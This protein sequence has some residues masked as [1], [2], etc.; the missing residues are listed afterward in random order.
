[1]M[2]LAALLAFN[3]T[4]SVILV[5]N[6]ITWILYVDL[7][8]RMARRRLG[9]LVGGGHVRGGSSRRMPASI[10]GQLWTLRDRPSAR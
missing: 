9:A 10:S 4:E 6:N 8:I 3:L 7:V 5:R 1:M 2:L